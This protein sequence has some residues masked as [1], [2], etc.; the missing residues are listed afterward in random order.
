MQN[1]GNLKYK[2]DMAKGSINIG[3]IEIVMRSF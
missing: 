1:V 2:E 3:T